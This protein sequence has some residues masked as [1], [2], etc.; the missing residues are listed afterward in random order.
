MEKILTISIAAY[1]I[2]NYLDETLQSIIVSNCLSDIEVLVINDGSTDSTKEIAEK[3]MELYPESIYVINKLNGG[4]GSTVNAAITYARGKYIKL[5]DGDDKI[6][7]QNLK[8]F[9]KC[10]EYNDSDMVV[11]HYRE[12]YESA[13]E[14][15]VVEIAG[16][17]ESHSIKIQEFQNA[18]QLTMHNITIRTELIKRN[19]VKLREN[20]FYTDNEFVAECIALSSDIY[21]FSET[22]YD[23]RIGREGQSISIDGYI[24]HFDDLVN[25]GMDLLSRYES[26]VNDSNCK[27]QIG[28]K[29]ASVLITIYVVLY[30][31]KCSCEN[32]KRLINFDRMILELSP[33]IYYMMVERVVQFGR[34][35]KFINYPLMCIA[36][37][38][39]R[40]IG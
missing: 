28:K 38:M 17:S 40:R 26:I 19:T 24:K 22:I 34:K 23:Y 11:S 12:F 16:L 33:D 35:V 1:N 7:S 31:M 2:E 6:I 14:K 9:I 8:P 5:L 15:K 37:K 36:M 30:N 4:W 39:K 13:N 10:L 20:C 25:V 29:A 3:Y 21:L 32:W 27:M 18:Y